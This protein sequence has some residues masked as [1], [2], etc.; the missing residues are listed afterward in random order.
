MKLCSYVPSPK[1]R[2]EMI[3][4]ILKHCY[5]LFALLCTQVCSKYIPDFENSVDPDHLASEAS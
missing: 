5:Y 4:Y 1:I 2:E 3:N